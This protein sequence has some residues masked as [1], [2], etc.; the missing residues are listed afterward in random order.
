MFETLLLQFLGLLF[1]LVALAIGYRLWAWPYRTQ[2]GLQAQAL[3]MLIVLTMMGGLIGSPFWWRDDP[4]SFSWDLPP[5]A[6]RML[7]AAGISFTVVCY[8]VLRNPT[9]RRQRLVLV[10]LAVY[11]LPL[12]AAIFAFHLDRFDFSA[13][14]TYAFFGIVALMA[15]AVIWFLL[16]PPPAILPAGQLRP[17]SRWVRM[18]LGLVALLT[19]VW[20]LA[21][22]WTDSG[23]VSWIWVWPGDLLTSRLIGVMLLTIAVGAWYGEPASETSGPMLAMLFVYG[24]GVTAAGLWN[25]FAGKAPPLVYCLAFS[26]FALGS[27][28][29]GL[30][31]RLARRE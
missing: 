24:T 16:R 26:L 14:I 2:A 10:L 9:P 6:G 27:L 12:A 1:L 20:G 23:P 11:L 19:L 15:G 25:L 8:L 28:V 7:A 13:L 18:W 17:T 21:L 30:I 22:F 4:S 3:L 5:L 29:V 31:A